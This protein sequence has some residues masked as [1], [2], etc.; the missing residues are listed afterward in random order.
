MSITETL[1]KYADAAIVKE[2]A[3]QIQRIMSDMDRVRLMHVCGTHEHEISRYGLRQLLPGNLE[4]IPGPGCPVCICPVELIDQAITLS[5]QPAVTV[6]TFGDMLRVPATRE[7]LD[8]AR[9]NGG[10]VKMIYGPLDAIQI[11][12]TNP[13]E[14]FVFFSVGFETTAS[15]VAGMIQKGVP[16]N[17]TFLIA[18]RYIP[19][20]FELL[21]RVH[22]KSTLQG[23]LLAGHAVTITGIHAYDY[24][25]TKYH[26]PCVAAGFTPVDI[27]SAIHTLLRLI[28]SNQA[29]V[30]NGY[31]RVVNDDGNLSAKQALADVFDLVPGNWRGIDTVDGTAYQLKEKYTV[32]DASKRFNA[33]PP[34]PS[35]AKHPGC[36]CHKIMLGEAPPTQCKLFREKCHPEN[37]YGP[38]MVSLEGTCHTWFHHQG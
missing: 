5:Y 13:D 26:L 27:F 8:G 29:K 30:L 3:D 38:C 2:L 18:N 28:Q 15:G 34:Y 16:E 24:M 12:V 23:F 21:M 37:P 6:L 4:V 31:R 19:P 20:V 10:S 33:R 14:N 9:K 32:L 36:I 17:L 35:R 11:A 22:E 7:S 25:E 1:N